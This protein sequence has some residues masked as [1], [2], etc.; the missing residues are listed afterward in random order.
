MCQK[1]H[2]V[3]KPSVLTYLSVKTYWFLH[4]L[5][6][7]FSKVHYA[8]NHSMVY[9]L[10]KDPFAFI[11]SSMNDIFKL[12]S[13][14]QCWMSISSFITPS[15]ALSDV[16]RCQIIGRMKANFILPMMNVIFKLALFFQWWMSFSSFKPSIIQFFM[17]CS[18]IFYHH[19]SNDEWH[20][21]TNLHFVNAGWVF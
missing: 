5:F 10:F 3:K 18:R 16:W 17:I 1:I 9:E 14:C 20:L 13:F 11:F 12:T 15:I 8:F 4:L 19:S 2:H 7:S 21:Q 6:I